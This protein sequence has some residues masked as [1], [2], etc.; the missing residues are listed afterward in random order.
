[1]GLAVCGL[2]KRIGRGEE[3]LWL[4]EMSC[5]IVKLSLPAAFDSLLGEDVNND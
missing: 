2:G 4:R 1:M 3:R 5:S